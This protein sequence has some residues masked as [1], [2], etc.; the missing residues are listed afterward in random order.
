MK[1]EANCIDI[2]RVRGKKVLKSH[3]ISSGECKRVDFL[4]KGTKIVIFCNPSSNR[5]LVLIIDPKNRLEVSRFENSEAQEGIE[6][7]ANLPIKIAGKQE[8]SII[9][10]GRKP[11]KEVVVFLKPDN[12]KN[13]G[14]SLRGGSCQALSESTYFAS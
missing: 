14:D 11:K 9:L 5:G 3:S 10:K 7:N 13:R 6:L 1:V 2:G 8:L 4:G 12:E